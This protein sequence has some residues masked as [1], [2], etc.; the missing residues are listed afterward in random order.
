MTAR[1][2]LLLLP[3]LLVSLLLLVASQWV[4]LRGS[5]FADLRLGRLGS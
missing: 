3:P 1:W 4:F 2:H 5:F